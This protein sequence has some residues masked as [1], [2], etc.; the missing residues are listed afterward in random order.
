MKRRHVPQYTL[1]VNKAKKEEYTLTC[2]YAFA[3]VD[4]RRKIV[5]DKSGRFAIFTNEHDALDELDRLFQ[6]EKKKCNILKVDLLVT[7]L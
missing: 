1:K 6:E 5:K 4:K 2:V 3:I 7:E